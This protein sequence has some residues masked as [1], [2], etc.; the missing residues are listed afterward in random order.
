MICVPVVEKTYSKAVKTAKSIRKAI[1]K[2]NFIEVRLDFIVDRIDRQKV[3]DLVKACGGPCIFTNR[4]MEARHCE[5]DE[6]KRLALLVDALECGS[7]F[8]DIEMHTPH[9]KDALTIVGKQNLSKVILSCHLDRTPVSVSKTAK[10]LL[11]FGTGAIKLVTFAREAKDNFTLMKLLRDCA[12]RQN[13]SLNRT[14]KR[15]G[16]AT[17]LIMFCMGEKGILSRVMC[18]E[19]GGFL[20]F[21]YIG[22]KSAQGQI[23]YKVMKDLLGLVS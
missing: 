6:K 23:E 2:F 21:A 12:E 10:K 14:I 22:K 8:I 3:C 11:S 17:K 13:K 1:G 18:Q 7:D 16:N 19:C 15:N 9:I 5:V 4:P 20:T